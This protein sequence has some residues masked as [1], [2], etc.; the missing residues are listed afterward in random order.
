MF[1][2]CY[3]SDVVYLSG[4][5]QSPLQLSTVVDVASVVD[6]AVIVWGCDRHRD[7]WLGVL[8]LG[9]VLQKEG[10]MANTGL[11]RPN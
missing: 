2:I 11:G 1:P 8:P 10:D 5:D 7:S 6:V 9:M 3:Y 4:H